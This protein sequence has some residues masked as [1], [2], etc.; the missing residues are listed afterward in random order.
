MLGLLGLSK[1]YRIGVEMHEDGHIGV[2]LDGQGKVVASH[3]ATRLPDLLSQ[4][5]IK[6]NT[7]LVSPGF[8]HFKTVQDL[9]DVSLRSIQYAAEVY[10]PF[11]ISEASF[12]YRALGPHTAAVGIMASEV[13][14]TLAGQIRAYRPAALWFEPSPF[15]HA[16]LGPA[17][18]V[19]RSKSYWM[20]LCC[21][22]AIFAYG[23]VQS[24]LEPLPGVLSNWRGPR[25]ERILGAPPE[26]VELTGIASGPLA[27]DAV[28]R[29][30]AA[31]PEGTHRVKG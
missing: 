13:L 21:D 29:E 18:F 28:A 9:D 25:P 22:S 30:L 19:S 10:L 31:S 4:L 3:E 7:V 5:P 14:A 8:E 2:V 20:T 11:S 12:T 1:N 6:G 17:V 27:P 24:S 23:Q 16:R 26:L 15:V